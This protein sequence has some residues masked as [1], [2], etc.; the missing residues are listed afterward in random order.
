MQLQWRIYKDVVEVTALMYGGWCQS[1][2][3]VNVDDDLMAIMRGSVL[4]VEPFLISR[5]TLR[6]GK[7]RLKIS[8]VKCQMVVAECG[9]GFGSSMGLRKCN[10]GLWSNQCGSGVIGL[11]DVEVEVTV[12]K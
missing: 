12:P 2:E 11:C 6:N 3:V 8:N 1:G 7:M 9:G 10:D 4:D 5:N